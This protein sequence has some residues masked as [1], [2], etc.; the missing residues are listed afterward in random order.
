[1]IHRFAGITFYFSL[2]IFTASPSAFAAEPNSF[3]T[4]LADNLRPHVVT[5]DRTLV[6]FRYEAK[7][8][9]RF[10]P[11][12]LADVNDRV[13]RWSERFF[14]PE[15]A[16]NP[17]GGGPGLYTSTDP[18]A[19][20]TWGFG[21]P[22]LF[23]FSLRIGSR[24][25]IGDGDQ[26][27][28][29]DRDHL[30]DLY[31]KMDCGPEVEFTND[32]SQI[33]TMFRNAKNPE[34]RNAMISTFKQL[35]IS[36]I[37][38]SFYSAP[39]SDCRATGTAINVINPRSLDL[40]KTNYYTTEKTIEG[41]RALT[42][43]VSALFH[44]TKGYF[45]T[46]RVLQSDDVLTSFRS[47]FGFLNQNIAAKEADYRE[48]KTKH[49]LTCGAQWPT[50]VPDMRLGLG[51]N[52]LHNRDA[53]YQDLYARTA[54]AYRARTYQRNL[55]LDARLEFSFIDMNA[56][57]DIQK[58]R[59]ESLEPSNLPSSREIAA[60]LISAQKEVD[61]NAVAHPLYFV[62]LLRR[63]GVNTAGQIF[64]YNVQSNYGGYPPLL[65]GNLPASMSEDP[66]IFLNRNRKIAVR[67]LHHCLSVYRNSQISNESITAGPCGVRRNFN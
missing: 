16:T 55:D 50:E 30:R 25:L 31:G 3:E 22:A 6:L 62:D 12:T 8:P 20:A 10:N 5:L 40:N 64:G 26:A 57:K 28:D 67:I 45:F 43:F 42:P 34:C 38:Y 21:K 17:D 60:K 52:E 48:W 4:V 24:V 46:Q 39:M 54:M 29:T 19:T 65:Q 41:D 15:I 51:L 14:N 13:S 33:V 7:D 27:S 49:I 66:T 36:A 44:E 37:T 1:M 59:F 18:V 32:Y 35:N 47:G 61:K 53:E 58:K 9:A 2:A 56:I 63:S 23:V 11:Q